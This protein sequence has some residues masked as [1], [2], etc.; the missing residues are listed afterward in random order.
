M[1]EVKSKAAPEKVGR[2]FKFN[3][4][5]A[6]SFERFCHLYNSPKKP[7]QKMFMV[8][9]PREHT[10]NRAREEVHPVYIAEIDIAKPKLCETTLNTEEGSIRLHTNVNLKLYAKTR[11]F[12]LPRRDFVDIKAMKKKFSLTFLEWNVGKVSKENLL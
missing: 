8:I 3:N 1:Y 12:D 5:S 7:D 10:L 4:I 9:L 11:W 2:K 6:G